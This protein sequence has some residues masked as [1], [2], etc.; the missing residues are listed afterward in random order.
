MR[1]RVQKARANRENRRG[2][3]DAHHLY[4]FE[5]IAKHCKC[6]RSILCEFHIISPTAHSV[7][8]D[9]K[10]KDVEEFM[11]DYESQTQLLDSFCD[12]RGAKALIFTY[13]L[14]DPPGIGL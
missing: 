12:K 8:G 14:E 9:L 3:L 11:I 6:I 5:F 4:I 2:A 1:Q 13:Q 7:S 10:P